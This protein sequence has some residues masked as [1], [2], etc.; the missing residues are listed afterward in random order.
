MTTR[1]LLSL[2]LLAVAGPARA[3]A[4]D[5]AAIDQAVRSVRWLGQASLRIDAGGAIVYLDPVGVRGSPADAD[6]VLVTHDHQD[7]WAPADVTRV[8]KPSALVVAPFA[9]D[10]GTLPRTRQVAPGQSFTEAGI[11]VEAVPAYN[12]VKTKYHP[13]AK[14]AV[15]YLLTARGVRIYVAGDTERIPEMKA[16]AADLAF[17]PLGQ[18]FTMSGPEEAAQ[19][20]LD[21]KARAAVPYHWG[22]YEGTR[23][24]ALRF[25][26]LLEGRVRVVL[27][28]VQRG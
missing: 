26:K 22:M 17:V 28:E 7:H 16:I 9:I 6:L 21:V 23:E 12:V 4:P 18:T 15:G 1:A 24:D 13:K 20:V 25:Q 19:A 5:E 14:G 2:L 11:S 10:E 27:L 8:V 3:T